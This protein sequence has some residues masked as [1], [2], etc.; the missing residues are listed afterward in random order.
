MKD[1]YNLE[2]IT[3]ITEK[4]RKGVRK[5]LICKIII[6]YFMYIILKRIIA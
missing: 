4:Y 2:R 3:E 1:K 6:G 5:Y